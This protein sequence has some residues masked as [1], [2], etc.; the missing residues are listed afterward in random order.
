MLISVVDGNGTTTTQSDYLYVDENLSEGNYLYRIKQIDFNG[1]FEYFELSSE[2]VINAPNSFSLE[3]NYPN[4]FNPSTTIKYNVPAASNVSLKVFD[5][6]GN[7]VA[8]LVNENKEAGSYNVQFTI[9]NVQFSSG[10]YFYKLE[11]DG[12]VETKKMLLLK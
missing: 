3:Q 12:F 9:N 10:I 1:N 8:T 11:T 6:I 5:A 7:E 2:V 4:P